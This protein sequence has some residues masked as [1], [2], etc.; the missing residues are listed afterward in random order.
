V[1][2]SVTH[3]PGT[4]IDPTSGMQIGHAELL[5]RMAG[6][7]VVL[8]GETHNRFDIHRWQLHVAAGL[9][10]LRGNIALGFEMFP[11]RVQPALDAF[12]AGQLDVEAFLQQSDWETVW[13]FDPALYLPLFAFCRE[14][15]VPMLALNCRRALVTEVGKGGWDSVAVADRDGLTPA[16]PA[17]PAHRQYLFDL[18]GGGRVT[19]SEGPQD[20]GFDR[21]VRAQQTWDRAFACNIAKALEVDNPPLVIGIIGRGHLE[22]GHGTPA[23]LQDLGIDR[24]SVL[25]PGDSEDFD[26]EG[27]AGMAQAV[28]R[29]SPLEGDIAPVP[30]RRPVAQAS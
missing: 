30:E 13:R 5:A 27:K 17:T 9:L 24:V 14:F 3:R 4:W 6:E 26:L 25:L 23:Q 28:F 15:G 20:P 18:T 21:F 19:Q 22:Y 10:A 2:R 11:V 7:R 1:S 16:L 29:L 12:V 8:L